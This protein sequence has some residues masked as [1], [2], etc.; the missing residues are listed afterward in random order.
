MPT[1]YNEFCEAVENLTPDEEAWW[2]QQLD[3]MDAPWDEE[4]D[5]AGEGFDYKFVTW[6]GGVRCLIIMAEEGKENL[7]RAAELVQRFL[8]TFRPNDW[9][10]GEFANNTTRRVV[11]AYGGG[12]YF[13][14]ATRIKRIWSS[15]WLRRQIKAF[16]K[17]NR[18]PSETGNGGLTPP[19]Y[20]PSAR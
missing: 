20:R 11:G 14:T 15:D 13:V 5:K 3:K 7:H 12:A 10:S 1:P 6:E 17:T 4:D 2:K 8:A 19:P 16:E 9:W 18:H